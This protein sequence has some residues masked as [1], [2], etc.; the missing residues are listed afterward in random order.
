MSRK[1]DLP[2]H[3]EL[4]RIVGRL[5]AGDE[6]DDRDFDRLFPKEAQKLAHIHWTPVSVA[7]AAARFLTAEKPEARILDVGAGG[8]KFC[9]VAALGTKGH[10]TGIEAD[11]ALVDAAK[12]VAKQHKIERTRFL[13]GDAL[14]LDWSVFDGLYLYNPFSG[15]AFEEQV[16]RARQKLEALPAGSRVA[17]FYGYGGALPAGFTVEAE[18]RMGA[19]V[20]NLWVK[21]MR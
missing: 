14:A 13:V 15:E 6:V 8:G 10:F 16:R 17:A 11:T 18:A 19:G 20:L 5:A 12:A 7:L 1:P 9:L 21:S 4:E 2:R 3:P